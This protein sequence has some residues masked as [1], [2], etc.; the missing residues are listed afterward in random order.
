MQKTNLMNALNKYLQREDVCPT[1]EVISAYD[2][3]CLMSDTLKPLR[4]ILGNKD[5]INRINNDNKTVRLSKF[6]K[7]PKEVLKK[8][9]DLVYPDFDPNYTEL[10]FRYLVMNYHLIETIYKIPKDSTFYVG[11]NPNEC[12]SKEFMIKYQ[13]EIMNIFRTLEDASKYFYDSDD[14]FDTMQGVSFHDDEQFLNGYLYYDQYGKVQSF[15]GINK[16]TA[17][18]END[19]HHL[20]NGSQFVTVE[21]LLK[22]RSISAEVEK[23]IMANKDALLKKIP[24][25]V[26]RLS[27]AWRVKVNEENAIVRTR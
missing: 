17:V 23:F 7:R 15:V 24:V 19:E 11:S 6:L 2:L 5:F 26:E 20:V 27:E 1:K 22:N 8:E 12:P 14:S 10:N 25:A 4:D 9:C 21:E 3:Y 18:M 13:D 16:N